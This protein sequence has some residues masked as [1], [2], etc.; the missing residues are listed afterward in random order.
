MT[1]LEFVACTFSPK[2]PDGRF[3]F[4]PWGPIGPCY[5]LS[6]QQRRVRAWFQLTFYG[7]ALA[8]LVLTDLTTS[9]RGLVV[10]AATFALLNYVLFWLFSIG[11]PKTDKPLPLTPQQRRTAM[12]THSRALGRPLLSLFVIVSCL[13]ALAGGAMALFLEE[14][15]TGLFCLSFFGVCAALFSWQL[16]IIRARPAT[17]N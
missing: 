11:L 14:W 6:P 12:V 2:L 17:K 3:V 7:V 15:L 13:F 10:F 9:T 4:R 16:W 1:V 5:L 8:A